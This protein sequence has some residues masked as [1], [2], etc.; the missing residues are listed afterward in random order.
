MLTISS[1]LSAETSGTGMVSNSIQTDTQ[2]AQGV[3]PRKPTN[4][5]VR[6]KWKMKQPKNLLIN[7]ANTY[8]YKYDYSFVFLLLLPLF[9]FFLE[10]VLLNKNQVYQ[11]SSIK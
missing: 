7:Y 2:C 10:S 3:F 6:K 8:I 11:E 1:N 9:N 5:L 4:V